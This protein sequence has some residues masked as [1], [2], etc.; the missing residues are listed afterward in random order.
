MPAAKKPPVPAWRENLESF[1]WAVIVA[2]T[3]RTF[4]IAPFKIPSGSMHPTLLE[5]DRIL[6]NKF[7]YYVRTPHPGEIVVFYYPKEWHP[8]HERLEGLFQSDASLM[9]RLSRFF[10]VGRPFIKRLAGVGG[11][12][13]EIQDGHVIVNSQRLEAPFFGVNH[14]L[15]DGFYGQPHQVIQVPHREFNV[16]GDNS[17]TSLDSRIWGFVPKKLM[18]GKAVCIFWPPNRLRILL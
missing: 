2:M 8:F 5:G 7:I 10:T 16:F 12:K 14:Y 15:N 6:V 9:E 4:I 18:I 3:I 17:R 1:V 13:I 11:D